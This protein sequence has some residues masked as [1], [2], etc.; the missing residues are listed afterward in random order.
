MQ[1]PKIDRVKLSQMLREGK[2]PA[3]CARFFGVS[4][5]AITKAKK[6]LNIS[7]IKNVAL[8]NAHKVVDKNLNAIEQL[9]KINAAANEILD[10]LMAWGRGDDTALRSSNARYAR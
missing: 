3:E 9:S 6:E 10:L 8:E 4:K 1:A 7:V 5:A 2:R